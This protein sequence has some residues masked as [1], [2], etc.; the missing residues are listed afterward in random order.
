MKTGYKILF[1]CIITCIAT[2]F[3]TVYIMEHDVAHILYSSEKVMCK[4]RAEPDESG[5]CPGETY[6]DMGDQGWNCCPNI[7]GDCF[8]PIVK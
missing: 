8:P 3:T 7:G 1:A 4:D 6:T 2:A 5:C